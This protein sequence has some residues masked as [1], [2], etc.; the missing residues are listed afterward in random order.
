M[1]AVGVVP[2]VNV[3]VPLPCAEQ[4]ILA[5]A[6]ASVSALVPAGDTHTF[7][8]AVIPVTVATYVLLPQFAAVRVMEAVLMSAPEE[9]VIHS[10]S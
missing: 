4:N 3:N 7:A 9:G 8:V 1:F 10:V 2:Q 6:Y 5:E